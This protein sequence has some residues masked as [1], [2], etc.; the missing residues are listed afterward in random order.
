MLGSLLLALTSAA[1]G[2]A[3]GPGAV[4]LTSGPLQVSPERAKSLNGQVSSALEAGRVPL[5]MS[6][7]E[8]EERLGATSK[9]EC[10]SRA[11]CLAA[12]GRLLG[13]TVVV[14]VRAA[15][16]EK[17]FAV[18]LEAVRVED[19]RVAVKHGFVL[20]TPV[21]AVDIDK[22]LK[23]FVQAVR[24]LFPKEEAALAEA[25][26]SP[27]PGE[28]S[29]VPRNTLLQAMMATEPP[30]VELSGVEKTSPHGPGPWFY[31]ATAGSIAA[32]GTSIVLGVLGLTS[33]ATLDRRGS[34]VDGQETTPNTQ[35]QAA[36]LARTAN[37]QFTG[38]AVALGASAALA[39]AAAVLW[40]HS[41]D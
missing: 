15:E 25:S 11:E 31:A 16:V 10:K 27:P 21:N 32:L 17:D 40:F 39:G 6:F 13:A 37:G 30:G 24:E 29:D 36:S 33:K 26:P 2:V 14:G 8:V 3:Q 23:P 38:A 12:S 28:P 18:V 9:P 41:Q 20:P 1:L 5:V 4:V 22:E 19:G 35:A 34:K 7:A